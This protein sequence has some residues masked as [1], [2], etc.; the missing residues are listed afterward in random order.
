M[1]NPQERLTAVD[2]LCMISPCLVGN[3]YTNWFPAHLKQVLIFLAGK[4]PCVTR[5]GRWYYHGPH[6]AHLERKSGKT[7]LFLSAQ[8]VATW[9]GRSLPDQEQQSDYPQNGDFPAANPGQRM[10]NT[11]ASQPGS[12]LAEHFLRELV[13]VQNFESFETLNVHCTLLCCMLNSSC[14]SPCDPCAT[15]RCSTVYCVWDEGCI[16]RLKS[17]QIMAPV[18]SVYN[19]HIVSL[20]IYYS[21]PTKRKHFLC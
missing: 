5:C 2:F 18:N 10:V 11:F 21:S 16:K 9:T 13:V 12:G 15:T 3:H 14:P 1:I 19:A 8:L 17:Q 20:I 4:L 7:H 6:T